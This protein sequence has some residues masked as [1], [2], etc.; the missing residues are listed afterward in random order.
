MTPIHMWTSKRYLWGDRMDLIGIENEAE[1]FPSGTL[2]DVL[3]EELQD[4]TARWSGL[5]KNSHPVERLTRVASPAVETLRQVRNTSDQNRRRE[6]VRDAQNALLAALGYTWKREAVITALD[7]APVIPIVAKAADAIGRNA[8][9]VI[10]APLPDA[11]D[12][13]TDPLGASF[14]A[15]QFPP[16]TDQAALLDR[17]IESLLAEGVFELP[18]GPRH[19]IVIGLSQRFCR[20]DSCYRLDL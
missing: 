14:T 15:D 17:S 13:A 8:L 10:E 6:L 16:D 20:K 5:E 11:E 2:S 4:I 18:D 19:V 1:F 12:E 9:W 7:G 3:K